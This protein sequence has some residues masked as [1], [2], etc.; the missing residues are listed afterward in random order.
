MTHPLYCPDCDTTGE[1]DIDGR[2]VVCRSCWTVREVEGD[3][4]AGVVDMAYCPRCR[5]TLPAGHE[6]SP[7]PTPCLRKTGLWPCGICDACLAAQKAD[8][9]ARVRAFLNDPY[10][11]P[12]DLDA[13]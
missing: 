6:C 5:A 10:G 12:S 4:L 2:E 1:H 8:L 13:P 7:D 11:S 9:D 3:L